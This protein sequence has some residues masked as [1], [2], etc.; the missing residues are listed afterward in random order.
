MNIQKRV[1]TRSENVQTINIQ[2]I[3]KKIKLIES[4]YH[5]RLKTKFFLFVCFLIDILSGSS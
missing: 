1:W 3:K 4:N 5:D 2:L